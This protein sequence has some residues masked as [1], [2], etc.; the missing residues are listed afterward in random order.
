MIERPHLTMTLWV[1][2]PT[3]PMSLG[4]L[5]SMPTCSPG[6]ESMSLYSTRTPLGVGGGGGISVSA[7]LGVGARG[8]RPGCSAEQASRGLAAAP[9]LPRAYWLRGLGSVCP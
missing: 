2:H 9:A 5:E 7:Q 8:E 1:L 4:L 6:L 3:A